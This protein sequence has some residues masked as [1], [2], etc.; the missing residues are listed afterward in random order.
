MRQPFVLLRWIL[1]ILNPLRKLY[2]AVESFLEAETSSFRLN[3]NF[4]GTQVDKADCQ[5]DTLRD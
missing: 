3:I 2:K 1:C 4:E 5:T